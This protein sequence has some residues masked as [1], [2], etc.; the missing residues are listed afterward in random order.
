MGTAA[1]V[2]ASRAA[3]CGAG[4]A[5]VDRGAARAQ[6]TTPSAGAFPGIVRGPRSSASLTR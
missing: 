3:R 5:T 6:S 4:D 1:A 2:P